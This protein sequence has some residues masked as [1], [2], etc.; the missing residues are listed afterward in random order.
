MEPLTVRIPRAMEMTGI[1]R[2]KLYELFSEG[3]IET[4]KVGTMTLVVVSSL[5]AFLRGCPPGPG[6]ETDTWKPRR[7]GR[8]K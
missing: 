3:A 5:R 2:S 7:R 1:G 4:V 8:R 6:T